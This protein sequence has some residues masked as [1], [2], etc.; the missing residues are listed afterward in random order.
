MR[1]YKRKRR[2]GGVVRQ[3]GQYTIQWLDHRS[4]RYVTESAR[5]SDRTVATALARE[6]ERS[7][8]DPTQQ[9][10]NS[11][12]FRVANA[13]ALAWCD[14]RV[15]LGTMSQKTRDRYD[16]MGTN[17]AAILGDETMVS[18]ITGGDVDRYVTQRATEGAAETTIFK[19]WTWLRIVLKL[20]HRA[21]HCGPPSAI[22]PLKLSGT[23]KPRTRHL[24]TREHLELLCAQFEPGRAAH[25]RFAVAVGA[26]LSEAANQLRAGIDMDGGF[27]HVR[28]TKTKKRNRLV[29]ITAAN[30]GDLDIVL[31][32]APGMKQL[33]RPWS[34]INRDLTAACKR[35]R[36]QDGPVAASMP[37]ALSTNDLRRTY[38][39]WLRNAGVSPDVI[40][41]TMGHVDSR[42][43]E[44]VYGQL[45]AHAARDALHKVVGPVDRK[46]TVRAVRSDSSEAALS[47]AALEKQC[48]G[49]ESNCRHAD[50]QAVHFFDL[51]R[52]KTRA[53]R[54]PELPLDRKWTVTGA[55][56]IPC[57]KTF[58]RL[59][60]QALTL[61]V[62]SS[63]R[64]AAG[65]VR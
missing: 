65:G 34:N 40:A 60:D 21:G 43:V 58:G 31:R 1:V 39:K 7:S 10:A 46:G 56:H 33:F 50:F 42:M 29:P 15:K 19:E 54:A 14:G 30:V 32:D 16:E 24:P 18:D 22:K 41:P 25:V 61:R 28:G 8:A 17:L 12:P 62:H 26:N 5:T 9:K 3:D 38:A 2:V 45:E 27:V 35:V 57:P 37:A 59:L 55:R 44:R 13:R 52:R 64:K 47:S 20:A 63:K 23:S 49:T 51:N 48:P 53:Q 36:K 11:I 6:R 4:G